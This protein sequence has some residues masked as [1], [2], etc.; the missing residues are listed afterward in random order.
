M[1]ALPYSWAPAM[2]SALAFSL[3]L[4]GERDA[5]R[6]EFAA[7]LANGLDTLRRD[8]HWLVTIGAL[9]GLAA[10]LA[11][12]A[13]AAQL[14]D[15]LLPYAHLVL[16]HDLLRS[17]NG[18]VAAALGSLATVLGRYD[19]GERHYRQAE[20]MAAAMG[21]L[22]AVMDRP[23]YV[24]LLV[25]RDRPGDRQRASAVL[26]TVRRDMARI[27]IRRSWQLTAIEQLGLA[28]RAATAPPERASPIPTKPPRNRQ[29]SGTG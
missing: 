23:G 18:T 28:P 15:L 5:G 8:E 7:L 27:G 6:R 20:A 3:C 26:D 29:D 19:E 2:R 24:H 1:M 17:V 25:S 13:A 12:R 21:G 22:T 10:L 9:S 16:V 11:D 4:R 14:Y